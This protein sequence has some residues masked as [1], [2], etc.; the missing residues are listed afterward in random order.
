MNLDDLKQTLTTM[1]DD[2]QVQDPVARIAGVDDKLRAARRR[3]AAAA[4]VG[5]AAAAAVLAVGVPSVFSAAP[6]QGTGPA[7]RGERVNSEEP[8]KRD[9]GG[10][11]ATSLPTVEDN[12]AVFYSEP[13]GDTLIGSAVGEPGQTS[14]TLT[15][16]P[17]TQALSYVQFCW[18]PGVEISDPVD[19]SSFLNG[20]P[21]TGSGC[22]A[23]Y[24]PLQPE[25]Q[26]SD[27]PEV[28]SLGWQH[29]GVTPGEPMTFRIAVP[30]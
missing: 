19:Y 3:K 5:A 30:P 25:I 13:G 12:G 24:G 23:R 18:Q 8:T 26:F 16:T 7:E 14:V 6:D 11:I 2:V 4:G 17:E 29:M 28:N 9:R 21:N 15:V 1:A 20:R 10:I 27:D 22:D